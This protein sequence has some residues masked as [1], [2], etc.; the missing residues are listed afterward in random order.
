MIADIL[1][2]TTTGEGFLNNI[3]KIYNYTDSVVGV[4]ERRFNVQS[5][6]YHILFVP[7][8]H[9]QDELE[10]AP[11]E[12]YEEYGLVGKYMNWNEITDYFEDVMDKYGFINEHRVDED[13]NIRNTRGNDI[14]L[15]DR[16]EEENF[17]NRDVINRQLN[18]TEAYYYEVKLNEPSTD[19]MSE[20]Y[21]EY[22]KGINPGKQQQIR[23]RN[24]GGERMVQPDHPSRNRTTNKSLL[25][26]IANYDIPVDSV[27]SNIKGVRSKQHDIQNDSALRNNI[28]YTVYDD[29]TN[30]HEMMLADKTK[31]PNFSQPLSTSSYRRSENF[32]ASRF[33]DMKY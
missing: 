22:S 10:D 11:E 28:F 9:G 17:K 31:M 18:D 2:P 33:T 8:V 25:D 15:K 1:Y 29:Q 24:K 16:I 23:S 20:N 30:P 3:Y 13:K 19:P 32:S 4:I 5:G 27:V 26:R 14:R 7:I 12:M 6:N 21:Y